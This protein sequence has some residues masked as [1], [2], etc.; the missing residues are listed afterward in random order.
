MNSI[1][2]AAPASLLLAYT[3]KLV[4]VGAGMPDALI[5]AVLCA[6]TAA[7]HYIEHINTKTQLQEQLQIFR[8]EL[9]SHRELLAAQEDKTKE[10]ISYV[11]NMKLKSV[12]GAR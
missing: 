7:G 4:I 1:I 8:D 3:I 11:S 6:L 9:K 5:V 12:Y 10:A 2:K